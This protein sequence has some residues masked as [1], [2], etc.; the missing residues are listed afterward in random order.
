MNVSALFMVRPIATTLLTIGVTPLGLVA[1]L[2]LPI[3]GV[4]HPLLALLVWRSPAHRC[5][6]AILPVRLASSHHLLT[7][8][9]ERIVDD[10]LR[11]NHLVIVL[12]AKVPKAFGD[13]V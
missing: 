5:Q 11:C 13:R 2:I 10:G 1:Y 8:L 6:S 4:P 9:I 3:A 7:V 12:K